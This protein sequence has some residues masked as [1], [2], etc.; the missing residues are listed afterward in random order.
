[1][2]QHVLVNV[3][4]LWLKGKNRP[5]YIKMLK[6]H[7]NKVVKEFSEGQ[8]TLRNMH[9]RFVLDCD[10]GFNPAIIPA[11]QKVPGVFSII[12]VVKCKNEIEDIKESALNELKKQVPLPRTFKVKTSRVDKNFPLTSMETSRQVGGRILS[13]LDG[14]IKVD[15]RSPECWVDVKIIQGQAFV[16]AKTYPGIGGLP[17]GTNGHLLTMLSGGFDSPVASYLMSKRGCEQTFIFFY[18][19][20]FVGEEVLD[21]IV[22]LSG[23]LGQYQK[24]SRLYVIP[25]GNM[26]KVISEQCEEKYRTVFFRQA[27]IKCSNMLAGKVKAHA[28]LTG[29]AL[30]QVSSQTIHNIALLDEHSARPIFRPLVGFNK[31]EIIDLARKIG[32]HDISVLPHDDA[33]A[34]FAPKHPII[35]PDQK[36]WRTFSEENDWTAELTECLDNASI[37]DIQINGAVEKRS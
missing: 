31:R 7:V 1:M 18:G 33:C 24:S 17:C 30:G 26:Q 15:I 14:Q 22:E 27:M 34:L 19:Y 25:F 23:V 21:K 32:T 35:K 28:L 16:S 4:E 8:F 29:D 2:Y 37:Y 5:H 10:D 12:P 13:Q 11:L 3:D 9:Q 36:Y 20:P 6:V